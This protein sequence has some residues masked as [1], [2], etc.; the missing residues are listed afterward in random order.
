MKSPWPQF[1]GLIVLFLLAAALDPCGDRGC[2]Q[3][4]I[5]NAHR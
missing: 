5:I 3:Q 4:E 1:I 2:S